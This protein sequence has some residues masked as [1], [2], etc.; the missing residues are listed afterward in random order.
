MA[1]LHKCAAQICLLHVPMQSAHSHAF[2]VGEGATEPVLAAGQAAS[3][4]SASAAGDPHDDANAREVLRAI[5]PTMA[6]LFFSGTC[7]LLI[8]PFLTYVPSDGMLGELLPKVS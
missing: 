1:V 5:W 7:G 2:A 3:V 4:A 8:F 6:G